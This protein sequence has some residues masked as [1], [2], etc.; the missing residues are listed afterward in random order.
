MN[1]WLPM[2][3]NW[4]TVCETAAA[5]ACCWAGSTC[6]P[7]RVWAVLWMLLMQL[8]MLVIAESVAVR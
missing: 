6:C 3:T 1:C 5:A 2:S 7:R 8:K 4:L